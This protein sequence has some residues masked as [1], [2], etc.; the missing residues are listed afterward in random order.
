MQVDEVPFSELQ[1]HGK[2][3]VARLQ[4]T[5]GQ[6]LLIRRRDGDNL[7]LTTAERAGRD[8]EVSSVAMRVLA[9]LL[10]RD[11]NAQDSISGAIT[12]VFPWAVFLP[13]EDLR[14]FVDELAETLRAADALDNP[15]PLAQSIAA[16]RNT[17]EAHAD[18]AV[19][20]QLSTDTGDDHGTVPAPAA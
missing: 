1:L 10:S 20:A 2:A 8:R 17:A 12:D 16:W 7:V 9:T 6:S 5:R 18:P 13:P 3:T 4:S 15:N 14:R 19:A 11:R